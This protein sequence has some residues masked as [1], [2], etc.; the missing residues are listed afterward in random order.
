VSEPAGAEVLDN[1]VRSSLLGPHAHLAEWHGDVVRYRPDV[2]SFVGLPDQPDPSSWANLAA[3]LGPGGMA[4]I[5]GAPTVVPRGWQIAREI[6]GVQ[7]VD[8]GVEAAADEEA[9]VLTASD[10]PDMLALVERT[11]PGPFLAGA[12]EM[13]VY[14]GIRR[15][16]ALIAMAGERMHPSGWT[17]VSA[18]CTDEAFRGQ[19][20]AARLVRAVVLEI[21]GRGETA[22]LHAA[23]SNVG[24][25]R[26]YESLGFELRRPVRFLGVRVPESG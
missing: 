8:T 2:A 19:G 1:P 24:A 10:V 17:E 6:D 16:G 7:L 12:T 20:L 18:V 14:R 21:S 5:A 11:Q 22:F 23:A 25:I 26:V 4:L 3:L 15:D 9:V 13:G